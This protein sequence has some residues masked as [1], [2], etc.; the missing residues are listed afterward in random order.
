MNRNLKIRYKV[1]VCEDPTLT[2]LLRKGKKVV[3]N[4][5]S[6]KPNFISIVFTLT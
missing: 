3:K 4:T 5:S 1:A 2:F 6:H